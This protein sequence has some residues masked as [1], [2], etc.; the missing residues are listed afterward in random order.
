MAFC[1][2]NVPQKVFSGMAFCRH[3]GG[4]DT[5]DLSLPHSEQPIV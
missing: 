4:V 2:A 5:L 3:A 1:N